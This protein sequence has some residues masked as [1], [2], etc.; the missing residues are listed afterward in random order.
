MNDR[1]TRRTAEQSGPLRTPDRAATQLLELLARTGRPATVDE[2]RR[3]GIS[4]PAQGIYE[5]QLAGIEID[6][7]GVGQAGGHQAIGYRLRTPAPDPGDP[8]EPGL[9]TDRAV[10]GRADPTETSGRRRR[11]DGTARNR[12]QRRHRTVGAR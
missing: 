5:L 6:R 1:R 7:V 2:L 9:S 10:R 3:Q 12:D 8:H 4:A 11:R